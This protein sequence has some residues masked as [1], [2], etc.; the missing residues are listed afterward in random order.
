[1]IPALPIAVTG[2]IASGKSEVTRRFEALGIAV[3]D[4]DLVSRELVEPGQPALQE[5]VARFGAGMLAA[6]GTLDR[7]ALR[8]VVF[9]DAAA[10]LDLE[11]ILHPRVRATL[12]ERA[13]NAASP[14]VLLAIPLLVESVRKAQGTVQA[15]AQ[16]G[17]RGDYDWVRRVLA[18]DVPVAVQLERVMRR[19]R[20]ERDAALATIAAQASREARLAI[21]TDVIVNDGALDALD[22]IVAR[23]HQRYLREAAQ[24]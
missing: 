22:P 5:I 21:A 9:S 3:V 24:R 23:L 15:P 11:A 12:R 7:R 19:D 18:V 1:M 14:Y 20:V 13:A 4:A 10:R 16:R 8:A 17:L 6:D 2:G